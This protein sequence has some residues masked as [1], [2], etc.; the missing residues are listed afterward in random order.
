MKIVLGLLLMLAISTVSITNAFAQQ[1]VDPA[2]IAD[3]KG[4]AAETWRAGDHVDRWNR[5]LAAFGVL[6]HDDPMTAQEAQTYADRGWDR[7]IPVVEAL[8]KLELQTV[9]EPEQAAQEQQS[10]GV[11]ADLVAT[12]KG[13]AAETWR[14][15]DHVDRWNRVL[16]AF[17]VL[18]HDDPMTA[19]EAQTYA[20]R[21]WDRWIPV[22]SALTALEASTQASQAPV[23][24]TPPVITLLGS[25]QITIAFNGTFVDA[26]ATCTDLVDGVLAVTT[27]GNVNTTQAGNYTIIYS[28]TDNSANSVGITRTVT[29]EATTAVCDFTKHPSE[30]PASCYGTQ[31]STKPNEVE[32]LKISDIS[33]DSFKVTWKP[34]IGDATVSGYNV[35]ITPGSSGGTTGASTTEYAATGLTA[36]IEYQ[37]SVDAFNEVGSSQIVSTTATTGA[38]NPEPVRNIKFSGLSNTGFT[39]T[40]DRPAYTA[41]GIDEYT[42]NING[43]DN[44]VDAPTTRYVA[45]GLTP[46][47]AYTIQITAKSHDRHLSTAAFAYATTHTPISGSGYSLAITS[48]NDYGTPVGTIGEGGLVRITI[49]GDKIDPVPDN[50]YLKLEARAGVDSDAYAG[51]INWGDWQD[52]GDLIG[53]SRGPTDSLGKAVKDLYSRQVKELGVQ[54]GKS[55]MIPFGTDKFRQGIQIVAQDDY[56]INNEVRYYELRV[57]DTSDAAVR[58]TVLEDDASYD[59]NAPGAI[60]ASVPNPGTDSKTIEYRLGGPHWEG[61]VIYAMAVPGTAT[62]NTSWDKSW[63]YRVEP[64]QPQGTT[65]TVKVATTCIE[66]GE[67]WVTLK[68]GTYYGKEFLDTP[69]YPNRLQV[70]W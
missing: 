65:V 16:A 34:P 30:N 48:D 9:S 25:Q 26:G 7:W 50:T 21:G 4:Y 68:V 38:T 62:E 49:T 61:Y 23:D 41:G 3:V 39:I 54:L 55:T 18:E 24:L 1:T 60:Y 57:K 33:H 66:D 36:N 13:Y 53:T 8:S 17:G 64:N 67:G 22:V 6:E 28:C 56:Y 44:I 43:N 15:G 47:T 59:N 52:A 2:L 37:I 51:Y 42:V 40:W 10:T 46:N 29:V 11:D 69:V 58:I 70:C 12:V 14:A 45:T 20:D 35:Y 63:L 32:N 5:V 31:T 27:T 19:Q